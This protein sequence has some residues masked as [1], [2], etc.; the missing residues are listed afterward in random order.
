MKPKN[1]KKT[2]KAEQGFHK[3]RVHA[4]ISKPRSEILIQ[5]SCFINK[6][7]AGILRIW[8]VQVTTCLNELKKGKG[9]SQNNS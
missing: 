9:F 1:K 6:I 5:F 8:D 7:I 4:T 2:Q 3:N